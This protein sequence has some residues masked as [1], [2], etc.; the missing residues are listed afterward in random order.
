M[1]RL[2]RNRLLLQLLFTLVAAVSLTALSALLITEAVRSAQSVLLS[3]AAQSVST[4][5][6]EMQQQYSY[7]V[8]SD[9]AWS[10][11]PE[12]ARNVS[13]R[14]ITQTVLRSY[15]GIEGGFYAADTF[16]GYAFPT[17]DAGNAKTDVP[18]AEQQWILETVNRSLASRGLVQQVIRGNTDLLVIQSRSD[19]KGTAAVWAMKRLAGANRPG[20]HQ[21]EL[22]LAGL[23]LAALLSIVGILATGVGLQRGVTQVKEGLAKLESDF[24]Y[25]LPSRSDELGEISKSIN[26]MAAVRG[27]LETELRREDRLRALGRLAS[28]LA[29][30]IRNP[31]N[32][33]RLTIQLLEQRLKTNTIRAGDLQLVKDE[34]DRMNTLLTDLLDLQRVRQPRPARQELEPVVR[35]CLDLIERQSAIQGSRLE[36]L[37]FDRGLSAFFDAQLLTQALVNLLLNA[38]ESSGEGGLVEVRLVRENGAVQLEVQDDGPGLTAEQRE[39]LFEAFYTTKTDGT[40]LGLAVSRELM[41]GQGGDLF[42]RAGGS[43]ATFV[44]RLPD[45]RASLPLEASIQPAEDRV[46]PAALRES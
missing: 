8:N 22:L 1:N 39:H 4:A 38:L 32:S 26:R 37:A 46:V 20:F 34:V 9:S 16:L 35:H 10:S 6:G 40:G 13:L 42:F 7:R 31:L 33:I 29:H 17:H 21:R 19:V 41:R 15:P 27:Q 24:T 28:G 43:G 25:Q 18:Q 36:L 45:D 5:I 23:V 14:G 11:L 12:S 44:I 3:E 30:E 2:L